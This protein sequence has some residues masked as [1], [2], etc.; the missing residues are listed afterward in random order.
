MSQKP[1]KPLMFWAVM[2]AAGTG[3]RMQQALAKQYIEIKNAKIIEH[4]AGVLLANDNIK[5]LVVCVA[6]DD[7]V[8]PTLALARHDRVV[9]TIGGATRAQSVL[10][11]LNAL[12][13]AQAQDW[14]LVH[15][16]AR[17]C[18]S[19]VMLNKLI[20]E[21]RDDSVGGILAM[22]VK[23]TLKLAQSQNSTQHEVKKTIDR[24]QIWQAQTPQMFRYAL[25]KDSLTR[26]L[27]NNA[28]ITDEASALE[29]AGHQPKLIESDARNLKVTTPEDIA[30]AE[31]LLS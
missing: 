26:A 25:L 4:S 5:Q 8:W 21:L 3:L 2:P 17:P 29:W 22:P 15:D 20:A 27:N 24:A 7:A 30:L 23:D 1:A 18:L 13:D 14:V 31:F 28:Q 6:Q 9:E 10:N 11:G 16:A 12:V 19:S